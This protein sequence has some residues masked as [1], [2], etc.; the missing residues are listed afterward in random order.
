[1]F[2][3]N[4]HGENVFSFSSFDSLFFLGGGILYGNIFLI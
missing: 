2:F 4:T 1:M 3:L